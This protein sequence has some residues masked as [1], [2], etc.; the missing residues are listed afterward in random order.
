[1]ATVFIPRR[2]RPLAGGQTQVQ[3]TGGTVRQIIEALDTQ[4]PGMKARLCQ[5]DGDALGDTLMRGMAVTIDGVT[6]EL[7]LLEKVG[8]DSEVH[9]LPAI[10][11][12]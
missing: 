3:V 12:G 6:S 7:G 8:P 1:M 10:A 4:C 11:G 5:A 2:L 9:F